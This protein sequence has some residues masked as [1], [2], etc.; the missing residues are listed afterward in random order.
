VG[1]VT[2]PP[3]QRLTAED[4]RRNEMEYIIQVD[5]LVTRSYVVEA[6]CPG[7]AMAIYRAG[8]AEIDSDVSELFEG[9][10][11]E[12]EQTA[13][14]EGEPP[15]THVGE[16]CDG[17]EFCNRCGVQIFSGFKDADE[18]YCHDHKP[19]TWD[20]EVAEMTEQEFD[21]QDEMYWTE[22][23]IGDILCECP[24]DCQ[25]RPSPEALQVLYDADRARNEA[26]NREAS[27]CQ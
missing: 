14:V 20:A 5:V 19:A 10:W 23:E 17:A 16:P 27:S 21:A 8:D 9:N 3:G 11:E 12:Q 22:W 26:D 15:C 18:R 6:N 13:R 2:G 7:D 1:W 24:Q 25:C 4:L